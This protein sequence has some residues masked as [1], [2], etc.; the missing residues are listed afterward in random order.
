MAAVASNS[1]CMGR[2]LSLN[3]TPDSTYVWR[4]HLH[5]TEKRRR[6]SACLVYRVGQRVTPRYRKC[7]ALLTPPSAMW[8][9]RFG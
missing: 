8:W 6:V 7:A 1:S 2:S 9:P 5:Q 3:L 4:P